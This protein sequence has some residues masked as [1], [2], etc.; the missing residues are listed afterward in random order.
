MKFKEIKNLPKEQAIAKVLELKVELARERAL[1]VSGT[2]S[3]NPGKIGK[4][5]RDIARLL[6]VSNQ[7]EA[8]K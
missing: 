3:E 5:R 7:K 2:R 8:K 1:I 6:T 4:I